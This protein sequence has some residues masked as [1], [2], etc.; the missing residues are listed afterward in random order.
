MVKAT[1]IA[2]RM[3][4]AAGRWPK[5]AKKADQWH[6]IVPKYLGGAKKGL[7]VRIPAAYHQEITNAFRKAWAYAQG[8]PDPE[9]LQRVL[10]E[11]HSACPLPPNALVRR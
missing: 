8:K 5:L 2:G 4:N 11:V 9:D 7:R 10:R 1:G 3:A 6:H